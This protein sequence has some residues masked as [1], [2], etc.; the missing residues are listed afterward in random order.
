MS[1]PPR[2]IAKRISKVAPFV[3]LDFAYSS[4]ILA[5]SSSGLVGRDR[6]KKMTTT[7][8]HREACVNSNEALGVCVGKFR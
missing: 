6:D 3:N 2:R 5:L 1:E 4:S 7:Y 8:A